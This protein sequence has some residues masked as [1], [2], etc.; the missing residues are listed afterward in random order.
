MLNVP[1]QQNE[2]LVIKVNSEPERT[3]DDPSS[4]AKRV[5]QVEKMT[6]HSDENFR[7]SYP[8]HHC[9]GN[10]GRR[11][12][13]QRTPRRTKEQPENQEEL[14]QQDHGDKSICEGEDEYEESSQRQSNDSEASSNNR[15]D[16]N[17]YEGEQGVSDI[18]QFLTSEDSNA[19]R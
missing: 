16:D 1:E 7:P 9:R 12:R 2:D 14:S 19:G 13:A 10:W 17:M 8:N 5:A 11:T 6:S 18:E 4:W 3:S 15:S